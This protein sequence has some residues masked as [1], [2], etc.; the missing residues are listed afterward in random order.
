VGSIDAASRSSATMFGAMFGAIAVAVDPRPTHL[1]FMAGT[2]A[3][4]D[5]YLFAPKRDGAARERFIAQLAPLD[6]IRYLA[7]ISPRPVLLQFAT[8]D[9]FV[10]KE[11]A[12]ALAEAAGEP[13]TVK[14]YDAEHALNAEATRDRQTWL[15]RELGLRRR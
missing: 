6:P 4:T 12:A 11:A 1:V 2:R 3:V 5:W 7:K 13:K 14:Y 9:K 15:P 8:H 10:S